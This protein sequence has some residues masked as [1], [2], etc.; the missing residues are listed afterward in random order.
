MTS[1]TASEAASASDIA[2]D[3][4]DDGMRRQKRPLLTLVRHPETVAN[5]AHVLQ[6]STD[7]PLSVHGQ[8]QLDAL[9]RAV[10]RAHAA[11]KGATT[12]LTTTRQPVEPC[13]LAKAPFSPLTQPG[14]PPTHILVSPLG[15]TMQLGEG[16]GRALHEARAVVS[17]GC[18]SGEEKD[19]GGDSPVNCEAIEDGR[20][21]NAGKADQHQASLLIVRPDL[22]ERNFGSGEGT[23]RGTHVAGFP[24]AQG[25]REDSARWAQRVRKEAFYIFS[26]LQPRKAGSAD[27]GRQS[28]PH[29][30][31][32][33]HGLWIGEFCAIFLPRDERLSFMGNTSILSLVCD[34]S[35]ATPSKER[36]HSTSSQA[37]AAPPRL[38]ILCASDA[39]HLA[40]VKRQRGGI[41]SSAS[42]KRQRTLQ[43]MWS[44]S[45][46]QRGDKA[47]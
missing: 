40:G 23:R 26:L 19:P 16:L 39:S 34:V 18:E 15:R 13:T 5:V 21:S 30:V 38:S 7:S 4:G 43:T 8:A 28:T 24:R 27:H 14:A 25:P 41:G 6:G 31:V 10:K 46:S 11:G 33:T 12:S 47:R 2:F 32:V 42:D 29:V 17:E 3:T 37:S 20:G 36:V 22:A 9:C 45:R 35:S 1:T 44:P